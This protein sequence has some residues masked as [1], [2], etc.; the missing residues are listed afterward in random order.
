MICVFMES[1]GKLIQLYAYLSR[2]VSDKH[3]RTARLIRSGDW[4]YAEKRLLEELDEA[5]QAFHGG[6]GNQMEKNPL[7]VE[8]AAEKGI[9]HRLSDIILEASQVSYWYQAFHLAKQS[10]RERRDRPLKARTIV[11]ALKRGARSTASVEEHARQIKGNPTVRTVYGFIGRLLA[12]ADLPI[13]IFAELD[14]REMRQKPY[15]ADFIQSM[16]K[17]P[18]L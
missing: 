4:R 6:H 7:L 8:L 15:L 9:G 1:V 14:L 11:A 2:N 5:I 10:L 17:G 16:Q 3:S 13:D 12:R 18:R